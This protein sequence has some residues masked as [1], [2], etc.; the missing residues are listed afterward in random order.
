MYSLAFLK[1]QAKDFQLASR[2]KLASGSS[3]NP[4][5]SN[6]ISFYAPQQLSQ[7]AEK[8]SESV[9][10]YELTPGY[11]KYMKDCKPD[12]TAAIIDGMKN[13]PLSFDILYIPVNLN[14]VNNTRRPP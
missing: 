9:S 11:L 3:A 2:V 8:L 14:S 1:E 6:Y 13:P 4:L 5:L 12:E 7:L 10:P